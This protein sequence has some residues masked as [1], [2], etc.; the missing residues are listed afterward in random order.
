MN[1][2]SSLPATKTL[3]NNQFKMHGIPAGGVLWEPI[4]TCA[5]PMKRSQE[6]LTLLV[7]LEVHNEDPGEKSPCRVGSF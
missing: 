6:Q 2:W 7:G 1:S 4:H 3:R 5:L